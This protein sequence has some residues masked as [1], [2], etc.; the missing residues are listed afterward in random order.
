MVP[1]DPVGLDLDDRRGGTLD[2]ERRR[3]VALLG[4]GVEY[5]GDAAGEQPLVEGDGGAAGQP[6]DL[7]PGPGGLVGQRERDAAW[8]GPRVPRVVVTPEQVE[9]TRGLARTVQPGPEQV[10]Q[11]APVAGD[12]LQDDRGVQLLS[13]REPAVPI[14]G[15]DVDPAAELDE[16]VH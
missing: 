3:L 14:P 9:R 7:V 5:G 16:R 13:G 4:Y 12:R 11:V 2:V 6:H 15:E 10:R 8:A 1:V